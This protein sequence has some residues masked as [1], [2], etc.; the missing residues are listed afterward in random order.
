MTIG[1]RRVALGIGLVVGA[2]VAP[3]AAAVP[4]SALVSVRPPSGESVW[5]KRSGS[6]WQ[7]LRLWRNGTKVRI[8]H[9]EGTY[10]GDGFYCSWGSL[11][12]RSFKGK[13][14]RLAPEPVRARYRIKRTGAK[15]RV[16]GLTGLKAQDRLP[17]KRASVQQFNELVP[18]SVGNSGDW[19][20]TF[21]PV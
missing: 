13:V 10:P 1:K 20:R 18:Q 7:M 2:V 14:Q 4:P 16:L 11:R 17:W 9:D 21:K 8:Y 6:G 19:C 3:A 5:I 15:L 12:G